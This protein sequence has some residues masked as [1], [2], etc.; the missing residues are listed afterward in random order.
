MK[1]YEKKTVTKVVEEERLVE[2][3]CDLCGFRADAKN[4][5]DETGYYRINDTTISICIHQKEGDSYPES[6]S[7][8][9]FGIDLCPGCFKN[10]LVPW[11]RSQG[12]DIEEQDWDW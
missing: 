11:L 4:G 1:R 7:G 12:A 6:G 5:W 10:K 2:R 8:T 3:K 9:E